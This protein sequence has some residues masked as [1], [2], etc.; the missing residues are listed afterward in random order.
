MTGMLQ[1]SAWDVF[2]PSQK[3]LVI[4]F[5]GDKSRVA[6]E[7]SLKALALNHDVREQTS[8]DLLFCSEQV[9]GGLTLQLDDHLPML[10]SSG[11]LFYL[12]H[13]VSEN[14]AI[15]TEM[16]HRGL[17]VVAN[18]TV[19]GEVLYDDNCKWV[20]LIPRTGKLDYVKRVLTEYGLLSLNGNNKM[21]LAIFSYTD[22]V[23]WLF[24]LIDELGRLDYV[25]QPVEVGRID[26]MRTGNVVVQLIDNDRTKFAIKVLNAEDEI[27][28]EAGIH[29]W[30]DK[31][32]ERPDSPPEIRGTI[33]RVFVSTDFQGASFQL[34]TWMSGKPASLFFYNRKYREVIIDRAINWS[35]MFLNATRSDNGSLVIDASYIR[36]VMRSF[37][38]KSGR[39]DTLSAKIINYISKNLSL[40]DCPVVS[41]HGDFWIANILVD[42]QYRIT[43]VVDWEFSEEKTFPLIDVFHLIFHRKTVFKSFQPWKELE[44]VFRGK[45]GA[46]NR[47]RIVKCLRQLNIDVALF[48]SLLLLYWV[49]YLETRVAMMEGN[50]GWYEAAFLD[51]YE[52][53]DE[54]SVAD[55]DSLC[56][57][58]M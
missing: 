57:N 54:Q 22:S 49:K 33:P 2:F 6:F 44:N 46:V 26:K 23:S 50:A 15:V 11:I 52:L 28:D 37:S 1:Q 45:M 36:S 16:R 14:G 30:L 19:E 31:M 48:S 42:E 39:T 34:E 21:Q 24:S 5:C 17:S 40:H 53:L 9:S 47:K 29:P 8:V 32:I 7:S 25:S 18:L 43:G 35:V 12:S 20:T 41:C 56:N 58:L 38:A 4:G 10:K 3:N 27:E 13:N 55:W 51:I